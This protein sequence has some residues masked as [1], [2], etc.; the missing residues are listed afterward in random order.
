MLKSRRSKR[1]TICFCFFFKKKNATYVELPYVSPE[2]QERCEQTCQDTF[3]THISLGHHTRS[4]PEY[5]TMVSQNVTMKSKT[6]QKISSTSYWSLPRLGTN[7]Y[8]LPS[9]SYTCAS[10]S[11]LPEPLWIR[12]LV[13]MRWIDFA[14]QRLVLLS[15]E[16]SCDSTTSMLPCPVIC[17]SGGRSSFIRLSK[18]KKERDTVGY[19]QILRAAYRRGR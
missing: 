11:K 9:A 2:H 6:H 12:Y 18:L 19:F 15:N 7:L 5:V 13:S 1:R 8:P 4:I 17:R 14:L 10:S 16:I 3:C